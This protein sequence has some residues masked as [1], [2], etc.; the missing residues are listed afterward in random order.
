MLKLLI[1]QEVIV[2]LGQGVVGSPEGQFR[3]YQKLIVLAS[4][5]QQ[6]LERYFMAL[7]LLS[8]QGS[9]RLTTNRW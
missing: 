4:P 3:A 2:E 1:E 5:A 8:K 7:T 6:S 9:D